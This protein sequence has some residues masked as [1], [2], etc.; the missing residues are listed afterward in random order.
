MLFCTGLISLCITPL[1][2]KLAFTLGAVDKPNKRRVNKKAIP[3]IGGLG[4]FIAV[5]ISIKI[6]LRY[7]FPTHTLF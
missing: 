6:L 4:I 2:R 7:N 3:T 5:N 1:I